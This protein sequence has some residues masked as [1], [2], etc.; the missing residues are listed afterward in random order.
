MTKFR[1]MW[2]LQMLP[3]YD[4]MLPVPPILCTDRI[5]NR[6]YSSLSIWNVWLYVDIPQCLCRYDTQEL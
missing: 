3:I 5:V 6:Y 1:T 4:A 2:S